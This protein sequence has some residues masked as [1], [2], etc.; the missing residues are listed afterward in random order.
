MP[1]NQMHRLFRLP[2]TA[3]IAGAV[4]VATAGSPVIGLAQST[5]DSVAYT[6]TGLNLRKGPGSTDAIIGIVPMGTALQ[7]APGDVRNDYAPVVYNGIP[8]W[9]IAEGLVA[10][11]EEVELANAAESPSG[12]S[13]ELY[14]RDLR[15]T[16]T[17]LMLRSGP[18]IDAEPITGMPE[19]SEVILTRE[20]YEN[21][22][23]TV[24]YGGARGWAYADLLAAPDE[25][26]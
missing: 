13:L 7:R 5:T 26:R 1:T 6:L 16:L 11:P 21:G 24:D 25:L 23:V 2:Q 3:L 10:T 12:E 4:L 18:S 9:V 15:V 20:G 19:G 22:Y 14:Q 8:G 17:P